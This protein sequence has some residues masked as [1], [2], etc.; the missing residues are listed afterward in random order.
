M[1]LDTLQFSQH[2][3]QRYAER[4]MNKQDQTEVAIFLF[5][6]DDKIKNDIRK[7]IEYG[8]LIYSGKPTSDIFNKQLVDIYLNGTWVIIVDPNKNN[9][10]TLYSIDLGLGKDFNDEYIEKLKGKLDQ[11]KQKFAESQESVNI[12]KETYKSLIL[13]NDAAIADYKSIIKSLQEQNQAYQEVIDTLDT[14]TQ[15]SEKAVRD[16][17]AIMIGKKIF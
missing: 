11:A 6:Q 4:I 1:N 13:D 17:V 8:E 7:M 14:N 10:I 9:V 16:I 5:E 12:E 3:K 15:L 2:A